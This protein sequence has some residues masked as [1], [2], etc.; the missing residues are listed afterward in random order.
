[1]VCPV[2]TLVILSPCLPYISMIIVQQI[3]YLSKTCLLLGNNQRQQMQVKSNIIIKCFEPMVDNP[4]VC[5]MVTMS[6]RSAYCI[7]HGQGWLP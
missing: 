3:N 4:K 5:Q 6:N 1:M 2:R 7:G